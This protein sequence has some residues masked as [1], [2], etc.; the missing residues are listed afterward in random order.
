MT[1]AIIDAAATRSM[2]IISFYFLCGL[3][4][5]FT[6]YQRGLGSSL[7]P[8]IVTLFF[9]CVLR[10]FWATLV[11]PRFGTAESLYIIYPISWA[12]CSFV[13]LFFSIRITRKIEKTRKY[14]F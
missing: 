7:R 12:L 8:M 9:V 14:N 5:V 10:V 3:M 13:H 11:F 6:G 1:L 2:I 4:E